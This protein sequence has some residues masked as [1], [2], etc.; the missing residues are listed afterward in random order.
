MA[1]VCVFFFTAA[2]FKNYCSLISDIWSLLIEEFG[3]LIIWHER[4]KIIFQKQRTAATSESLTELC[5]YHVV[6]S[7]L[8]E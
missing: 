3:T 8:L 4:K 6:I 7:L 2:T 1:I 5:M